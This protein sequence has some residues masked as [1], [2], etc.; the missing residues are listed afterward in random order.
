MRVIC[1][2]QI[3]FILF[4]SSV[5]KLKEI[6]TFR[7]KKHLMFQKHLN[8]SYSTQT[9]ERYSSVNFNFCLLL[10]IRLQAGV[11][12]HWL[13]SKVNI[14]KSYFSVHSHFNWNMPAKKKIKKEPNRKI[15]ISAFSLDLSLV[16]ELDLSYIPWLHT[17]L[18]CVIKR[19]A[20]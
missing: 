3:R 17:W 10:L 18:K 19:S 7:R 20:L 6:N 4:I 13:W 5:Q 9:F 11:W 16:C 15:C 12:T 1:K 14:P 2:S 8:K